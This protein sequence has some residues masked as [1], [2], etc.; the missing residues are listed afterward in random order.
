MASE[1]VIVTRMAF[2][3]HIG[4]MTWSDSKLVGPFQC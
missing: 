2:L 1:C 3:H 4:M